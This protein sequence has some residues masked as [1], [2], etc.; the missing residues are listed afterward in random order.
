MKLRSGLQTNETFKSKYLNNT[1][2]KA[3]NHIKIKRRYEWSKVKN[4]YSQKDIDTIKKIFE[5]SP[6][7]INFKSFNLEGIASDT[8]YRNR[9]EVNTSNGSTCYSNRISWENSLFEGKYDFAKKH[10]RV[11]YGNLN[12]K[13]TIH[14]PSADVYGNIIIKLKKNIKK[15]TTFCLGDSCSYHKCY[16]FDLPE[17]ILNSIQ[18]KRI[19]KDKQFKGNYIETQIHGDIKLNRDVSLIIAPKRYKNHDIIFKN[20]IK[21]QRHIGCPIKYYD[22]NYYSY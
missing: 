13:Q 2:L 17:A 11:K 12:E 16:T 7:H 4:Q 1:Q 5:K 8:H 9:F 15:R 21:L 20:L 18:G 22:D 3:L 19:I 6:L 14:N 10:E